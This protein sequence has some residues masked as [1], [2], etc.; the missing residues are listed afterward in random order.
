MPEISTQTEE[1]HEEPPKFK[2][3][4]PE[5]EKSLKVKE[6]KEYRKALK[7]YK[8]ELKRQKYNDYMRVYMSNYRK[9]KYKW[10]KNYK[11]ETKYKRRLEYYTRKARKLNYIPEDMTREELPNFI[12]SL[13]NRELI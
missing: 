12:C 7:I 8:K 11:E 5:E 13:F 1:E 10:D 6:R 3:L 2:V 4:T 9:M